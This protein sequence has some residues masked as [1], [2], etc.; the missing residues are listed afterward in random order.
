MFSYRL[1]AFTGILSPMVV[2]QSEGL[3]SSDEG[4]HF[5]PS[6]LYTASKLYYEEDATQAEIAVKLHT[7]RA[8][9]SRLLSE[10][11]RQGIV[12]IEVIAPGHDGSADL[13][14]RISAALGL[15]AVH[16]SGALPAST[17]AKPV[18]DVMGSVLAPAVSRALAAV[19]LVRGDILL[20]SSGRTMYEVAQFDLPNLP[21]VVVAPTVGG[22][23]QPEGWYQTN[24]I[25]RRVAERIGGRPTY[26]FAPAL[27]GP[28]LFQTLQHDPAIQR[29]LHLWPSARCVLTGVGAPPMLRSQAPQFVDV[30]APELLEAVGDVCSRFFNRTGRVVAFPGAERLIAVD[31][32]TLRKIPTVIA[33]AAGRDKVPPIIAGA[34]AHYFN[35]LVT[36]PRTAEE[37]LAR[38]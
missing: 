29:V 35:Q 17:A 38:A 12:R 8:T 37:I 21:G 34:R 32:A 11:R 33:V 3:R 19:G 2:R 15:K 20:V 27:P 1:G 23:D 14:A 25:T 9:V 5:A 24:E 13:A 26:L 16:I 31:L 10:A 22:T 6:L 28:E 36:D 18:E 7:S 4:G 30:G